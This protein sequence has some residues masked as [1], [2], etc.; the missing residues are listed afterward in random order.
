MY[1]C[2]ITCQSKKKYTWNCSKILCIHFFHQLFYENIT[3]RLY[4]WTTYLLMYVAKRVYQAC[5]PSFLTW[6]IVATFLFRKM[7][8][9]EI[10]SSGSLSLLGEITHWCMNFD[11]LN[12]WGSCWATCKCNICKTSCM[13]LSSWERPI[14]NSR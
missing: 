8:N 9:W 13:E 7:S 3:A 5:L 10:V 6:V 14:S 12:E 11:C 1:K 2:S 4:P